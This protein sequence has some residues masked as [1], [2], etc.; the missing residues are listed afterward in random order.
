MDVRGA[1]ACLRV[2]NSMVY[3][4]AEEGP[5][6]SLGNY[7]VCFRWLGDDVE[8]ACCRKDV[9]AGE[10]NYSGKLSIILRGP[11]GCRFRENR[12]WGRL[13]YQRLFS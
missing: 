12:V 11:R 10:T 1:V 6:P 5:F 4:L 8:N 13:Q 9:T 2:P 3:E 7:S